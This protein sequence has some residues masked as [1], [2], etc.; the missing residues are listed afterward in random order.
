MVELGRRHAAEEIPVPAP[1]VK[2]RQWRKQRQGR[3]ETALGASF[4][5]RRYG[6]AEADRNTLQC[7]GTNRPTARAMRR[8]RARRILH[9]EGQRK[10]KDLRELQFAEAQFIGKS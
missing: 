10:G 1:G 4:A 6:Q 5:N 3:R 9:S 7:A 2:R 8:W